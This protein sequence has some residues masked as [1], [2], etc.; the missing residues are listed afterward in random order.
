MRKFYTL[1]AALL[2]AIAGFGQTQVIKTFNVEY[3]WRGN[4]TT[5]FTWTVPCGVTSI[6]VEAW[7]SGAGGNAGIGGGGG[8]AY[9][10][11]TNYSVTAGT[12]Y[13]IVVG[14][15][16]ARGSGDDGQFSR[17]R[18][19]SDDIV[20][21][22]GGG[23][24]S[25][26]R[27][28]GSA[29]NSIGTI[30]FSGGNGGVSAS[31]SGGAG[32]GGSA[33]NAGAGGNGIS[34]SGFNGGSGG[35]GGN[36]GGFAGG[37]GGNGWQSG[38]DGTGPGAG[39]GER[40][41]SGWSSGAGGDGRVVITYY[42][43]SE[44]Y[45]NANFW[46]TR[47]ITHVQFK[48]INRTS[49]NQN[50]SSGYEN[51]CDKA[52]VNQGGTYLIS[53][54]GNISSQGATDYY[55]VFIDWDQNGN[56]NGANER[57]NIGSST[58]SNT[59]ITG[60]I[61][62]PTGAHLG[63]TKMRVIKNFNEY[64]G[65]ACGNRNFGQVEDYLVEV[66]GNCQQPTG[67]TANNQSSLT[68]CEGEDVTLRQ[69]G[70]Q[71]GSGQTWKWYVNNPSGAVVGTSTNSDASIVV[72]PTTTTTYY[73]RAEGGVCGTGGTG[74][75]VT[76]TV[77][78][79]PTITHSSGSLNQTVCTSTSIQNVVFNIGGDATGASVSGLPSGLSGTYNSGAKTFTISGIPTMPGAFNYTVTTSGGAPCTNN[80]ISG[81]ITVL[82]KLGSL[83]Y[84]SNNFTF[85]VGGAIP[86]LFPTLSSGSA[87]SYSVSPALP[88]GLSLNTSTGEISGTPSTTQPSATYTITASNGYCTATRN[89]TIAI[90]NTT[91]ISY[92]IIPAGTHQLCSSGS[93]P[94]EIKLS[95]SQTGI[96]YQLY[97][98]GVAVGT[99]V[100]GTGAQLTFGNHNTEGT[101]YIRTTS[102]CG[103]QMNGLV[104]IQVTQAPNTTFAY[105]K[106]NY[107][108]EEETTG[109][110][111]FS[112]SPIAGLFT[113]PAGIV[114]IDNTTGEIDLKNS[115]PG[116][117]LITYTIAAGGGCAAYSTSKSITITQ[118][119]TKYA[120][121]GGGAFCSGAGG[122]PITLSGSQNG[123][124]YQLYR[125][126]TAVGIPVTG[127]GGVI[128]FGNQTIAGIYHAVALD[129]CNTRMIGEVEVVINPVPTTPVI[130]V[131]QTEICEGTILPLTASSGVPVNSPGT[132]TVNSGNL[133]LTIPDSDKDGVYIP[134]SVSGIP[135]NAVITGISVNFRISHSRADQLLVNLKGPNGNVLNIANRIG[136]NNNFNSYG[137][138][139][140]I[141]TTTTTDIA[142]SGNAPF[143]GT[144]KA[145]GA[146]GVAGAEF[147]INN[148]SNV[149]NLDQLI[150][151]NGIGA[152]GVWL[153]SVRDVVSGTGGTLVF[154][155]I[156][157]NYKTISNSTSV[158]WSA[159]TDLYDD[160]ETANPY[161]GSPKDQV[162]FKPA[163]SGSKTYT[164]TSTNEYGCTASSPIT[165]TV[166]ASPTLKVAADYC[167]D[168]QNSK[169]VIT[170]T[171][172]SNS[173]INSS[174]WK[175]SSGYDDGPINTSSNSTIKTK[176][177]G[178]FHVSALG[179]NGCLATGTI[180]IA[181]E[182]VV[183]GDFEDGDVG[184]ESDYLSAPEMY[185]TG[186]YS[187]GLYPEDRYAVHNNP[188]DYH[189]NFWGTDHTRADGTG[190][191]MMVN[192]YRVDD[193]VIWR[194]TVTVLPNTKYY[195]SAYAV[196][197]NNVSPFADLVFRVN[198]V[199]VGVNTGPLASKPSNN[200]PGIWKRF[201]GEWESNSATTAVIE[202]I[203]LQTA[204]GGNDF[205]LDDI[206][207]GTLSTF[208][209]LKSPEPTT[210]QVLCA[211]SS[212][213]FIAYEAGGKGDAPTLTWSAS[214]P[215]GITSYWNG[216]DYR[217]M[218]QP[219]T[220]GTYTYSLSLEVCDQQY[221]VRTGTVEVKHP[222]DPGT[223]KNA[224]NNAIP[225]CYDASGRAELQN[226]YGD[227]LKWEYSTNQS[228]WNTLNS[229]NTYYDYTNL[230]DPLYLRAYALQRDNLGNAIKGCEEAVSE[231]VK[232]GIKNMWEGNNT[233]AWSTAGNW[234]FATVPDPGCDYVIIPDVGAKPY[235]ILSDAR[236]VKNLI[237]R[238]NASVT[239]NNTGVLK[240]SGVINK[241]GNG[242]IDSKAGTM[243][244]NGTAAQTISSSLFKDTTINKLVVSNS[245]GL[246][247]SG[248]GA[249]LAIS[250]K[251]SFGTANAK[252]NTGD[253]LTLKST[254]QH[255]ASLGVVGT[256]NAVNGKLTVERYI[257][258]GTGEGEHDKKWIIIATN[259]NGQT[260]KE[261]WMEGAQNLASTGYGIMLS[262][263]EGTAG[264]WDMS[265]PSP[266]IKYFVPATGQGSWK[267]A[268]S[269]NVPLKSQ[270]AWMVFVRGDRSVTG[271]WDAPKPTTLRSKG[272]VFTGTKSISIPA[273]DQGFYLVGN[274]YP[275]AVDMRNVTGMGATGTYY[276]WNPNLGGIYGLGAYQTFTYDDNTGNY[277]S[278][279]GRDTIA[280]LLNS[281][282]GFFVQTFTSG[283]NITFEEADKVDE[284]DNT[285]FFR[286]NGR[287]KQLGVLRTNI[288]SADGT[289]Q[290][291]TLQI[292]SDEY[293]NG[294]D[295]A[296]GRKMINTG[297]NL[298]VKVS[299]QLLVVE[300]R[301]PLNMN[302]TIY[303]NLTGVGNGKYTIAVQ[304][305]DIAFTGLE[306]WLEDAFT[307]QRHPVNMD[308]ITSV[309]FDVT[310]AAA[311]KAANRFRM[312]FTSA[313]GP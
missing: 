230:Q 143:N 57:Y 78:K 162:F 140:T 86:T 285:M 138:S 7:G 105:S 6:K 2:F 15:G 216:R 272:T 176:T 38:N 113:A 211:E 141:N 225:I 276:V 157:I 197:L 248:S 274:P 169:I 198:G 244:F 117:Y 226:T 269:A 260:I 65:S 295:R 174:S 186:N 232:L 273:I 250:G 96:S 148:V 63:L 142:S 54:K 268:A 192:G 286:G 18:L 89:I 309:A 103:T 166:K 304:T 13:T 278:V 59:V 298:S 257:N 3:D 218:G 190:K 121:A 255:T 74:R 151:G 180:S 289:L 97:R 81:T 221:L 293:S 235:P 62:V 119:A 307:G 49:S 311:S 241:I 234:S 28:G 36:G 223:F 123:I 306:G 297:I 1:L 220:P 155:N 69:T 4:A 193:K 39:G 47:P 266:A 91:S 301:Q 79:T 210:A 177:S 67:A 37:N 66:T 173:G 233:S 146:I 196:S 156:S 53:V 98:D 185:I 203:N 84:G 147:V 202:I 159:L 114:F 284:S 30:R 99:A 181:Q 93:S 249:A 109:G 205:G 50:S 31:G 171:D 267:G 17:F 126:T 165:I 127:N 8:G 116:T 183:N 12:V 60:N 283:G 187:T 90:S 264:G 227:I 160:P 238:N 34:N 55:T 133:N 219:A 35:V 305:S 124:S 5:E 130:S 290:D 224:I 131:S 313:F 215:G 312:V 310:S 26:N 76:V 191:F 132:K 275:S 199:Q 92:D 161:S 16:A 80:S 231:V 129:A 282:Q 206:S 281:G 296:D 237:I 172:T 308:G 45:C 77:K 256:S 120:I 204:P 229:N 68:I 167:I 262:G 33:G 294:V 188:Q 42:G 258:V 300:R 125:G 27:A 302:D 200:N 236:Q 212:L 239:V 122:V 107:C 243:E 144:Y 270:D 247:V 246:S 40:G 252:I 265:S 10:A 14:K 139:T 11:I 41:S 128:S 43:I 182:L 207:F 201:Y 153:L 72:N 85:C 292:F 158:T 291:G 152:N 145:Q 44:N 154:F 104:K 101:Y 150:E 88:N 245:N 29:S 25:G 195:F 20:A 70:G 134:L 21:A 73:V 71:L 184:F 287:G 277:V 32:G 137:N 87:S 22:E 178:N 217:L 94:I 242:V 52:S 51:F 213:D 102:A 214:N 288:L 259:T 82:A 189:K 271:I 46:V 179:T 163:S 299:N 108:S 222:S 263:P 48:E 170:A 58:S 95:G 253:N 111:T 61:A 168:I 110:V 209:N 254:K 118:S 75:T 135:S 83:N 19:G 64:P 194:Q 115:T 280:N 240:V 100:S 106:S 175:W 279:P 112:G 164:A 208:F 136:G 23:V 303:Y 261:S 56:F 149:P 9:A 228:T 251:L 24:G